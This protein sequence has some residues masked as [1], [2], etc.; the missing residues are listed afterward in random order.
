[1]KNIVF[2]LSLLFISYYSF[3]QQ[4]D[5]KLTEVWSPV[6][7]VVTPGKTAS[8]APSDAIVLF[9]G[10]DFSKWQSDKGGEVKWKLDNNAMTVV[11]EP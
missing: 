9:D 2:L 1:M 8:D 5:P 10:K 6:P 4:G 3:S 7:R 11:P